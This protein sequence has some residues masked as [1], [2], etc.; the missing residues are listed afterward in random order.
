MVRAGRVFSACFIASSDVPASC[1]HITYT[2]QRPTTLT[3]KTAGISA[4]V[5]YM[6]TMVSVHH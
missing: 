1:K 5:D 3:D 2:T 6:L 4:G